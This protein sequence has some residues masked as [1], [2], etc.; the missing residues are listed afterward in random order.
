MDKGKNECP[1]PNR[2][3]LRAICP[4]NAKCSFVPT[5]ASKSGD[6]SNNRAFS[7]NL[8]MR[9]TLHPPAFLKDA[10]F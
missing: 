1:F 2:K 6:A 10:R 9:L 3:A 8:K 4:A 5:R 7:F